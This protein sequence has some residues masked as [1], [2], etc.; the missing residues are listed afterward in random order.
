MGDKGEHVVGAWGVALKGITYNGSHVDVP[1]TS[2]SRR[3]TTVF[4]TF[5]WIDNSEF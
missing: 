2:Q 1:H 3:V 4:P 5:T